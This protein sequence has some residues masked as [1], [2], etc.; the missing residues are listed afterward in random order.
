MRCTG[1]SGFDDCR[2]AQFSMLGVTPYLTHNA[3]VETLGTIARLPKGSEV[4]FDYLG[5]REDK[6][7][8]AARDDIRTKLSAWNE[9]VQSQPDPETLQREVLDLGFSQVHNFNAA[10]LSARH[11]QELRGLPE[12]PEDFYVMRAR[13]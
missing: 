5:A 12:L 6:S 8:R 1:A 11:V 2:P 13:V 10:A 7:R 9:P 3:F 4:V